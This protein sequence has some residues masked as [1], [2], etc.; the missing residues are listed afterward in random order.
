MPGAKSWGGFFSARSW[1]V[2]WDGYTPVGVDY[3]AED[4]DAALVGVEIDVLNAGRD[5]LDPSP[6]LGQSMAKVGLQVVGFG[7]KNTA[8]IEV[9]S[10]DSDDPERDSSSRRGSWHWGIIIRNALHTNSTVL[11]SENGH[12]R[13]GIDLSHSI[14]SEGALLVAGSG[15]HSGIRFDLGD[16]GEVYRSAEGMLVVEGGN[17]GVRVQT[18]SGAARQSA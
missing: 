17:A 4:F 12:I 10:E 3:A 2:K 9:R 7:N 18:R 8:A 6:K 16:G 14:C 1:P 5:A 11:F 13:R 15:Q